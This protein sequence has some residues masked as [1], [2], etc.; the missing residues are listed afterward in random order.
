MHS[1]PVVFLYRSDLSSEIVFEE[2]Y[3]TCVMRGVKKILSK[4][5][6][7]PSKKLKPALTSKRHSC[8]FSGGCLLLLKGTFAI[9]FSV[10][11]IKVDDNVPL[12]CGSLVWI[13]TNML[14]EQSITI[15]VN[16]RGSIS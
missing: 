3:Q 14:K 6:K 10:C 1:N 15:K 12:N 7:T 16:D 4:T 5:Q 2:T 9:L 13:L 11:T 8:C